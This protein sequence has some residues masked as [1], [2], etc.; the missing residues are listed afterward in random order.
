[1]GAQAGEEA[2][3]GRG[4]ARDIAELGV[5][6]DEPQRHLLAAAADH[7]RRVRPLDRRGFSCA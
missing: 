5:L 2:F 3:D 1:M 4:V 7:D 6:G